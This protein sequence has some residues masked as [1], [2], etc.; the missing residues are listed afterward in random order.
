MKKGIIISWAVVILWMAVIFSLSSQPAADSNKISKGI[1]KVVL[2]AM[3]NIIPEK[4]FGIDDFNNIIR[5]YAHFFAYLLLSGLV[6]N[7]L[8][9]S[10]HR[11]WGYRAVIAVAVCVLYAASDE[12]HQI[13]VPGRS[14][15]LR[16][17]LIDTSGALVGIVIYALLLRFS[18]KRGSI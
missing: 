10:L 2:E 5:K 3:D 14:A 15:Q 11:S 13:F 4:E 16:D 18:K 8:R 7:A 12:I 1:T 6:L 9:L 17:V